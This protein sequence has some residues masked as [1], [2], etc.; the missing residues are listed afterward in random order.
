MQVHWQAMHNSVRYALILKVE[1]RQFRMCQLVTEVSGHQVKSCKGI[2]MQQEATRSW[3]AQH[4]IHFS[5]SKHSKHFK[6]SSHSR[7]YCHPYCSFPF[8]SAVIPEQK[9]SYETYSSFPCCKSS[10]SCG[11]FKVRLNCL[12]QSMRSYH[13]SSLPCLQGQP[14]PAPDLSN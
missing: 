3:H 12:C 4:S 13:S 5:H 14:Q 1:K 7:D 8:T 9:K 11:F 6:H 2:L 10:A